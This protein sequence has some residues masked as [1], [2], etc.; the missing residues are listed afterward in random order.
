MALLSDDC[1]RCG[2]RKVTFD[3]SAQKSR[4]I[5]R[6]G[7][8]EVFEVFAVCRHCHKSTIFVIEN[9]EYDKA[10]LW[11]NDG[12]SSYK[13]FL[14]DSFKV[15]AY[16]NIKD[17]NKDPPPEHVPGQISEVFSEGATCVSVECWNAAG[18]MFRLVVDLATKALLPPDGQ[19]PNAKIR[20][21]LGLRLEWLFANNKLPVDLQE[22]A[23]CIKE[24]GNDG[25]HVGTLTKNDAL[26]LRDFT[27]SLLERLYAAP[28]RIELAA[29][30][31]RGR[32]RADG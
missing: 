9:K 16:I 23:D 1:P 5:V 11:R 10:E 29:E 20:R 8:I 18:A 21:S 32:R 13:G 2:T 15:N 7:W 3:V 14:N 19:E 25:A 30:R 12:V 17:Q 31:R 27:Y 6:A 22:L 24:D 4:G 28:K 26:D